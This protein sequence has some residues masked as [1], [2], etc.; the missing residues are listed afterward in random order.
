[1]S[2]GWSGPA[3]VEG[4]PSDSRA[5]RNAH[6]SSVR[7]CARR[8]AIAREREFDARGSRSGL[9]EAPRV[10]RARPDAREAA[11]RAVHRV[12]RPSEPGREASDAT[13]T[14]VRA[15]AARD[16]GRERGREPAQR[17]AMHPRRSATSTRSNSSAGP[18]PRVHAEPAR[19]PPA[20]RQA[21]NRR[22]SG[23]AFNQ[24]GRSPGTQPLWPGCPGR[25]VL[26]DWTTRHP[27][28][29]GFSDKNV[30]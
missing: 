13:G 2:R 29:L 10:S 1:M 21:S 24:A 30:N 11:A 4:Q 23:L 20:A 15:A 7:P 8:A 16:S 14:P 25:I 9:P 5:Q 6:D 26:Q 28:I 22:A 27:Y 19:G 18:R 17:L 3:I 12:R